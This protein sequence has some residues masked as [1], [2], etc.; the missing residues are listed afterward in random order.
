M[1]RGNPGKLVLTKSGKR[2][3]TFDEKGLVKEKVPVYLEKT[4]KKFDFGT[5]AILCDPESLK[6]IGYI[7]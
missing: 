4:E 7:D 3:R 1:G 2:G 5:D 6:I